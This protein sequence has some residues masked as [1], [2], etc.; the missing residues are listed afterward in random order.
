[1]IVEDLGFL[2]EGL[3][4]EASDAYACSVFRFSGF[5]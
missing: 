2:V 3:E 5:T 1:M 4:L